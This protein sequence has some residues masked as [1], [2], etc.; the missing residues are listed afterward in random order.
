MEIKVKSER[1]NP[2]LSRREII[3]E[4]IHNQTGS[5]PPR[6]E[7]R[8]ALA[9]ALKVNT[10]LVF[11]KKLETKTGTQIAVG[12]ANVYYTLEQ[13]VFIEPKYIVKRNMV[14][15]GSKAEEKS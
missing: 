8:K 10:D 6:L 7:V 9:A 2:L 12:T 11:I 1:R 3:F 5:T 4:V 15:E 14:S 13:A